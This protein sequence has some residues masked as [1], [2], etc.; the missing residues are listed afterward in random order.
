MSP[1]SLAWLD[2]SESDRR[3]AREIV[4]MFSQRESRDDLG[5]GGIRDAL[6]NT[7]FPG[8]SVLLTRARY[9]LFVPWLYREGG[10]RGYRGPQLT[11]WVQR[12]ERQLIGALREGGD[13][14]GLIGRFAGVAIQSLPSSI[15]WNSLQQFGILRHEGTEAQI[16]GLRQ[17]SRPLDDATELLEPS[18]SV[19]SP[20][21]PTAPKDF[22]SLNR[23]DFAL[24]H[25]EAS[26]LAEKIAE[27]VPGTMLQFLASM[28]SR[29]STT[30]QYVWKDPAA[31]AASGPVR[32]ALE[33][34]RRF[35]VSMHGAALLY[36]VLLAEA[37]Y[38]VVGRQLEEDP[39]RSA[40][41]SRRRRSSGLQSASAK[42]PGSVLGYR[43]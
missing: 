39:V 43:V 23:C 24:T 18:D 8:T 34:T 35:A 29:P 30:A 28:G 19:W 4:Q 12:Q 6:S 27:A 11:S 21:M 14:R 38:A 26:W 36:N 42:S 20:S 16:A 37:L 13:H 7:L 3:R 1:A 15:Y 17:N 9:F 32:G 25:D 40:V 5:L 31:E 10:R 2:Y 22:F 33:E 41:G